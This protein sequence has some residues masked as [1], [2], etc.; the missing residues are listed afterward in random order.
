MILIGLIGNH[1]D[2]KNEP[3]GLHYLT[4]D[5]IILLADFNTEIDEQQM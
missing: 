1:F 2:A 5:K 3:L 4:Y